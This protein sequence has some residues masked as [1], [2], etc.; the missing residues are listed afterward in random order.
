M[1]CSKHPTMTPIY[2][3]ECMSERNSKV[4][5]FEQKYDE[6]RDQVVW[7]ITHVDVV[8]SKGIFEVLADTLKML[9]EQEGNNP[10][11]RR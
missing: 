11:R 9:D 4:K 5:E 3:S 2:C 10:R 6:L 1:Y 8:D 7:A